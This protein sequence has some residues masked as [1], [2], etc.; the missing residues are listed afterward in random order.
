[1]S[2]IKQVLTQSADW[3]IQDLPLIDLSSPGSDINLDDPNVTGQVIVIPGGSTPL[4]DSELQKLQDY[5]SKGGDLIIMAG[6]NL[7]DKQESLATADNLNNW[8][9]QDFGL[10]FNK[11]VV[12]DS[13]Q[14]FQTPL[15]PVATDLDSGSY[16]TSSNIPANSALIFEVPNS[17]TIADTAPANVTTAALVH[18]SSTSFAKTN[19][20]QV[21]DNQI[22][23]TDGDTDGPF[24]LAASAENT[25][26][27]A[28]IVLFSSTSVADD[29]Y[30]SLQNSGV[31]NLSVGLNSMVWATD[32]NNFMSQV[33]VQQQQRPQDTPLFA[34]QQTLRY[35]NFVTIVLLPFGVLL[36]GILVWWANRERA[37]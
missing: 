15:L 29:N 36:I 22:S 24:V 37:R 16:V 8:L 32:F 33:T 14:A 26:T 35:I 5:V 19:L 4:T 6:T 21:L 27:G 1:M 12:L 31:D 17:I 34:D 18:S 13:T 30:A 7:N 25:Q 3:T 20:Q 28:R 11:D 23:K 9:R 10:S 2:L